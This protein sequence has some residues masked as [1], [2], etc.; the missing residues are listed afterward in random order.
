MA[1]LSKIRINPMRQKSR[2]LLANPQHIHAMIQAG[3]AQ[4]PVAERTLWRLD[5]DDQRAPNLLI[6]TGTRPDWNHIVEQAGWPDADGEHY[7]IRP[8]EPLLQIAAVGREF[9][10]KITASPVQNTTTPDKLTPAQETRRAAEGDRRRGYRIGHRTAAAQT[11]WFLERAPRLG[12]T[13]P[14]LVL[15]VD[16]PVPDMRIVRRESRKFTK[17]RDGH[18]HTVRIETATFEGRLKITDAEVF[19][20]TLLA[21]IGPSKAYGC[22]LLTLASIGAGRRPGN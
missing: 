16:R 12:F 4:Q 8:Y 1:Y 9:A 13:I 17:G 15:D 18:K 2:I 21:G 6:L 3:I 14:E 11:K 5:D 22:G 10:F 7:L 20:H 19:R